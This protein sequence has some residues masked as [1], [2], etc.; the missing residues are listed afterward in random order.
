MTVLFGTALTTPGTLSTQAAGLLQ[1]KLPGAAVTSRK[2]SFCAI[3]PRNRLT[4]VQTLISPYSLA[5]IDPKGFAPPCTN[6]ICTSP[7]AV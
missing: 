6:P 1:L 7:C 4:G 3:Q 2:G 5:I